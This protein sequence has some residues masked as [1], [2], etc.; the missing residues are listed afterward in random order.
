MQM[1]EITRDIEAESGLIVYTVWIKGVMVER[2]YDKRLAE[3]YAG[4]WSAVV[5]GGVMA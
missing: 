5:F 3:A 4:E 2:F 1:A